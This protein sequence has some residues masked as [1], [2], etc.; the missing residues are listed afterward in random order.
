M[1]KITVIRGIS[2]QYSKSDLLLSPLT[3]AEAVNLNP[4]FVLCG[5]G[6]LSCV[7]L[8]LQLRILLGTLPAAGSCLFIP[9]SA[10]EN[11]DPA[12]CEARVAVQESPLHYLGCSDSSFLVCVLV[13]FAVLKAVRHLEGT[14]EST[15]SD[16]GLCSSWAS[17]SSGRDPG[18]SQLQTTQAF[19][20]RAGLAHL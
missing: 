12:F 15:S 3:L 2:P 19:S 17:H 14:H 13:S 8:S 4:I 10:P 16:G 5:S 7:D 1:Y 18:R 20:N 9:S 11:R 6:I